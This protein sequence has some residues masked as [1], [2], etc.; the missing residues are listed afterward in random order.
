[1]AQE[2]QLERW[3][4]LRKFMKI[5]L[6]NWNNFC[7]WNIAPNSIKF[8]LKLRLLFKFESKKGWTLRNIVSTNATTSVGQLG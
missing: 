4:I 7:Y 1:L 8:E 3:K 2:K 6:I 5:D